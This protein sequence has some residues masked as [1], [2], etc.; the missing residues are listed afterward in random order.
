M[1]TSGPYYCTVSD[2]SFLANWRS[3]LFQKA[4]RLLPSTRHPPNKLLH[5][6]RSIGMRFLRGCAGG[7]SFLGV[8]RVFNVIR[9]GLIQSQRAAL[10]ASGL[11]LGCTIP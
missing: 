3:T 11:R 6:D 2:S 1:D 9:D 8:L 10:R 7:V 5:H 4:Q